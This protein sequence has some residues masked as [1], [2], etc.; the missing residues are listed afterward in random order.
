MKCE[1]GCKLVADKRHEAGTLRAWHDDLGIG[2]VQ[3]HAKVLQF[4][5]SRDP[6]NSVAFFT[7]STEISYATGPEIGG[8]KTPLIDATLEYVWRGRPGGLPV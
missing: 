7:L 8:C 1:I 2:I 4:F 5:K 3:T 6:L